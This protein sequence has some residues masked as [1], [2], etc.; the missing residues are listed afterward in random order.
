MALL[1]FL[2]GHLKLE[3][4]RRDLVVEVG[5]GGDPFLRSDIIVEKFIEDDRERH[6]GL[7]LDRTVI[8]ADWAMLPF[9]DKSIDYNICSHVLEHIA[10]P[11]P[12]LDEL[13]RVSKRGLIITPQGGYE[14]LHPKG[15]HL[16]YV[17][18]KNGIL[19]LKQKR[20]WNEFPEVR[21]FYR[22]MV[23]LKGYWRFWNDH[24]SFFNTIFEWENRINYRIG[25]NGDFDF[26]KFLKATGDQDEGFL[27][28]KT[29]SIR[30]RGKSLVGKIF[31][32]LISAHWNIDI[33]KMICCPICKGELSPILSDTIDTKCENCQAK[34]PLRH[35][36][37]R[38]LK[39][40]AEFL[41]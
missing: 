20:C 2:F 26:S 38:L 24:Y 12:F 4:N 28:A 29:T 1:N 16:W 18:N 13:S 35:S 19:C 8:G 36:I 14:R 34:F 40:E 31:R 27:V 17:W 33:N 3:I 7:L 30:Q 9:R 5:A 10:D 41:I 25:Q 15:G 11:K 32:P 22:Q 6:T 23:R 21:E 39:E 37:P